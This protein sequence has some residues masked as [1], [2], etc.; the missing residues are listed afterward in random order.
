MGGGWG[1]GRGLSCYDMMVSYLRAHNKD[2]CV[3]VWT[4]KIGNV[5]KDWNMDRD[6]KGRFTHT[7]D[8]CRKRMFL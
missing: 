2:V 1:Q 8:I 5:G 3:C 4:Q 7:C 6:I